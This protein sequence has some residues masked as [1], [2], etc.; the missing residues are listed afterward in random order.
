MARIDGC[1][2]LSFHG[3]RATIRGEPGNRTQQHVLPEE[4]HQDGDEQIHREGSVTPAVALKK[5]NYYAQQK[6]YFTNFFRKVTK[7]LNFIFSKFC[8][9]EVKQKFTAQIPGAGSHF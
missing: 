6:Y 3:S 2:R 1:D 4:Q 8:C 5:G 7:F 9:S